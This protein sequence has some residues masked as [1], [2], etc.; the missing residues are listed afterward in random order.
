MVK[1][2]FRFLSEFSFALVLFGL[3]AVASSLGSII[4][5]DQPLSFYEESYATPLFGFLNSSFLLNL[6]LDHIYRTPWFLCLL[7][8]LGLS[9]ASCT[10]KRQFPL[11]TLAK[12]FFFQKK[13]SSFLPLAFSFQV[14]KRAYL[15]ENLILKIQGLDYFIYQRANALYGYKG[16]LGRLSPIFVHFSLLILLFGTAEGAFFNFTAQEKVTKGDTFHIENILGTGWGAKVPHLTFRLNDAWVE[17]EK[18]KVHQFYSNISVLDGRGEE[19][20]EQT[21]SVNHPFSWK[22][23]HLY[24]SDWNLNSIRLKTK[25]GKQVYQIPLFPIE[26]TGKLALT[27]IKE[28]N[29]SWT[30]IVDPL[31][32]VFVLSPSSTSPGPSIREGE[33]LILTRSEKVS[34]IFV[35][36]EVLS[37]TGILIQAQPSPFLLYPGFG[38]L[39]ITT[40]LSYLPSTQFWLS[41]HPT[42]YWIGSNTNR[43]QGKLE[44]EM[45]GLFRLVRSQEKENCFFLKK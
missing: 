2:I 14:S 13:A 4:E 30:L 19:T 25:E 15:Q 27:W 1:R 33:K 37:T 28:Q 32:R 21:I 16:L 10:A 7:I 24:Q 43:G 26:K 45:E 39:L 5:Q 9:L 22:E 42:H 36:S 8:L 35:L 20:K 23:I 41:A 34:S 40:F 38:L 3:I 12:E 29:Q 44:I 11:F 18:K 17:Y 6:G 31:H